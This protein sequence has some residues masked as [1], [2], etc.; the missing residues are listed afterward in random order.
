MILQRRHKQAP[1]L[2]RRLRTR[3][4]TNPSLLEHDAATE[5][6]APALGR[7]G[8][9]L[10][11]QQLDLQHDFLL[12]EGHLLLL[13]EAFEGTFD[14]AGHELVISLA[15]GGELACKHVPG[16]HGDRRNPRVGTGVV[17][18]G[19]VGIGVAL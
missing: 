18:G 6:L 17:G 12:N 7:L 5:Y 3:V 10:C 15:L 2:S 8:L 11:V 9:S 1:P 19:S 13:F 14:E 16:A 4:F